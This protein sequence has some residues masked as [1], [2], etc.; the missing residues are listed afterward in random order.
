VEEVFRGNLQETLGLGAFTVMIFRSLII[1]G[2]AGSAAAMLIACG[3][4]GT[5]P[6]FGGIATSAQR[7]FSSTKSDCTVP[8]YYVFHGSCLR[9]PLSTARKTYHLAAYKGFT[10]SVTLAKND[11]P[12]GS[13]LD[14]ADATGNGDITGT[15]RGHVFPRY[16]NPCNASSCPGKAFLYALFYFRAK[17]VIQFIGSSTLTIVNA[18][19][20]PHSDSCLF[21]ALNTQGPG[22]RLGWEPLG[23][24]GGPTGKRLS[25]TFNEPK[26]V[27]GAGSL[28]IACN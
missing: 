23:E 11:A 26:A 12:P 15:Y 25:F 28:A 7:A 18:K 20:Y 16:P 2:T 14:F 19:D 22:S 3:G 6:P 27:P 1:R 4:N 13:A 24:N 10:V 17:S 8:K 21:A 5:F 9:G